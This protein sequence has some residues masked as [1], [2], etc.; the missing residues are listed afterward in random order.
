M[1]GPSVPLRSWDPLLEIV[2]A[3]LF[4]IIDISFADER[5]LKELVLILYNDR[6]I[7]RLQSQKLTGADVVFVV[8]KVFDTK[9]FTVS[10]S[11]CREQD[12]PRRIGSHNGGQQHAP[13]R[14][15]SVTV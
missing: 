9:M 12:R 6:G 2:G 3:C 10:Y 14:S 1:A 5:T 8:L 13:A 11:V 15:F 4:C 7:P